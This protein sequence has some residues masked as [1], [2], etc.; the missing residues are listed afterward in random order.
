LNGG[1]IF[2]ADMSELKNPLQGYTQIVGHNSVENIENYSNN[3]GRVIFCDCLNNG[4]Y[5]QFGIF[6]GL[7]QQQSNKDFLPKDATEGND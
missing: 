3:G 2:W 4:H 5:L 7:S 1:D 6:L